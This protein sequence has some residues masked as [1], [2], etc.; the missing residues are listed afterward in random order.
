M[1]FGFF[2]ILIHADGSNFSIFFFS[3][4]APRGNLQVTFDRSEM[5][6]RKI[7]SHIVGAS[8]LY[9]DRGVVSQLQNFYSKLFDYRTCTKVSP[10][11][12]L[13]QVPQSVLALVAAPSSTVR[14]IRQS[15][16]NL[17]AFLNKAFRGGAKNYAPNS[18]DF[19][20][21]ATFSAS[22][23]AL[24]VPHIA[25]TEDA[26]HEAMRCTGS[27]FDVVHNLS[28]QTADSNGTQLSMTQTNQGAEPF[29]FIYVEVNKTDR[30]ENPNCAPFSAA[31][32][33]CGSV[34]WVEFSVARPRAVRPTASIFHQIFNWQTTRPILGGL[35]IPAI[36]SVT[37]ISPLLGEYIHLC[38]SSTPVVGASSNKHHALNQNKVAGIGAQHRRLCIYQREQTPVGFSMPIVFF[39]CGSV[40]LLHERAEACVKHGGTV[41]LTPTSDAAALSGIGDGVIAVCRDPA[42]TVFGLCH[43]LDRWDVGRTDGSMEVVPAKY[44]LD[45]EKVQGLELQEKEQTKQV[46]L[47]GAD[48]P[49]AHIE[50]SSSQKALPQS[51]QRPKQ[52]ASKWF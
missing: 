10:A 13:R 44:I 3:F 15:G 40:E 41:L 42:G 50:G 28:T 11:R 6:L 33:A 29:P 35:G 26:C 49:R 48:G 18:T 23:R 20:N 45:D 21:S 9:A 39:T 19:N 27:G 38:E 52:I 32:R 22:P 8:L 17:Q 43:R 14:D 16:T 25:M 1:F 36:A 51:D 31:P 46:M 5:S 7:E 47:S 30:Q 37:P 4:L 2:R 34:G 12:S 24:W